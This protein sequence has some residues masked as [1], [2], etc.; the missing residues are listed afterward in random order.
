MRQSSMNS[1]IACFIA[2]F[3]TKHSCL[4]AASLLIDQDR[5]FEGMFSPFI[6]AF[7]IKKCGGECGSG[8]GCGFGQ[9]QLICE[10]GRGLYDCSGC[11]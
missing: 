4:I 1:T 10:D 6:C 7:F 8:G 5:V 2:M 9:K 11:G 3:G